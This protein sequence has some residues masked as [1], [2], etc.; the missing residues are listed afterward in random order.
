MCLAAFAPAR[1]RFGC[2]DCGCGCEASCGCPCGEVAAAAIAANRAADALAAA[3]VVATAAAWRLGT[4]LRLRAM[5][6]GPLPPA[7][8]RMLR[9]LRPRSLLERMVQRPAAMLRSLRPLRLTGLARLADA[10]DVAVVAGCAVAVARTVVATAAVARPGGGGCGCGGYSSNG[11]PGA[12]NMSYAMSPQHEA[13][14]G[15]QAR[16][17]QAKHGRLE[18]KHGELQLRNDSDAEAHR[19]SHAVAE[20]LE[21]QQPI[22]H[23]SRINMPGSPINMPSNRTSPTSIAWL[24]GHNRN[25]NNS[26]AHSR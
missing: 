9:R 25:R 14:D 13:N 10:V 26:P 15:R 18:S 4:V 3:A 1:V 6:D 8:L 20:Q 22:R 19:P 5:L 2:G 16:H 23:S 21:L 12:A 24:V 7:R 11:R 17:E